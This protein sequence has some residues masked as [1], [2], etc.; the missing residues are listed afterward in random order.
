MAKKIEAWTEHGP[1][2]DLTAPMTEAEVIENIIAGT[3]QSKGSVLGTLS[4]LD[5]QLEAGLKAGRIVHLPNGLHFEPVGKRDGSIEIRV[6]VGQDL[7]KRVNQ[8]FRG[9]WINGE[10]KG[11]TEADVIRRWNVRHPDDPIET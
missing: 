11:I 2:I 6:R 1:R 8:D 7:V 5:V 10:N 4:E 3:N 9:Q